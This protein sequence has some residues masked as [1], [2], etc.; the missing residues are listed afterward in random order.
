MSK[1]KNKMNNQVKF[2]NSSVNTKFAMP[3]TNRYYQD[4][5]NTIQV[6][7]ELWTLMIW[8]KLVRVTNKIK[9]KNN[10]QVKARKNQNLIR[11]K[12][13]IVQKND[14]NINGFV[15]LIDIIKIHIR[16]LK[17][18]T[19]VNKESDYGQSQATKSTDFDVQ[20]FTYDN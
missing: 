12:E 5:L 16:N 18:V 1:N 3:Y 13:V 19:L 17:M 9:K 4:H 2:K 11:E 14:L 6:L 8:L 7:L 20:D 15:Y 10:K